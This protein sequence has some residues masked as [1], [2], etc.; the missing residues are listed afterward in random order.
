M[1]PRSALQLESVLPWLEA[2]GFYVR[3]RGLL[4]AALNRP[5]TT[6]GGEELYPGV[7]MKAAAL[8]ES[9][10][11]SHPFVDGNKRCGVLLAVLMLRAHDVPVAHTDSNDWFD[12]AIGIA[13]NQ[14]TV[15]VIAQ[16]LQRSIGP[17]LHNSENPEDYDTGENGPS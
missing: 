13:T 14:P 4:A 10:I 12:L 16:N 8:M 2:H 15:E 7:W 17:E 3:D 9:V 6:F 1:N 5:W 11:T